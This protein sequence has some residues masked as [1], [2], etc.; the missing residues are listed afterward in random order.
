VKTA[1]VLLLALLVAACT[2]NAA[3]DAAGTS[4]SLT[5]DQVRA[6]AKDA[7]IYGFP[8]VDDYRLQYSFF[9]DQH[10]AAYKGDWNQV[11][12]AAQVYGPTDTIATVNSDVAY[13]TLGAD[14]RAEPLV[15]TVPPMP[16]NRYFSVQF[17]DGYTYDFGYAGTRTTGNG[18]G[19]FLLAGPNWHGDKPAG[20]DAVFR[21]GTELATVTYRT[22]L[23]GADDV[24]TVRGIQAGYRVQPLSAFLNQPAPPA[25]PEI[26]FPKALSVEDEHTSPQFFDILNFALEFAPLGP[27]DTDEAALRKRFAGIG[28]GADKSFDFDGKNP[29][30]QQAIK[31]GMADAW[32]QISDLNKNKVDTGAVGPAQLFGSR[33]DLKGNYLYRMAGAA[34]DILGDIPAEALF[35]EVVAD[36]T[37]APLT[38]DK[39]YALRFAP[40]QLPPVDAFW[41][42]TM[43]SSPNGLLVG[44]P[45]DRY[46]INSSM[47][48]GLVKD[49]DGG[50]TLYLQHDS[51]GPD[52]EANWLPA[53]DGRFG[54]VLRMYIPKPEAVSGTWQP[55]KP[56]E[57]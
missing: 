22:Q 37:G 44:N 28:V 47:L 51:P 41:S 49:P 27:Q 50:V 18:G 54:T 31:D 10:G 42:L 11:H 34:D 57:T 56:V 4:V 14:L 3:D 39:K 35:P 25:P 19:R 48:P 30:V 24:N 46:Q 33:D 20:I 26:T 32:A 45:L 40:G 53:P 12:S 8:M 55:P 7:Y 9:V 21:S 13:S 16:P 2:S 36:S 38:G 5:P 1:V 29:Q 52:R 6:I 15:L 43:Y 23:F 17:V